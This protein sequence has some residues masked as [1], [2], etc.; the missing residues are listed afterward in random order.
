[1]EQPVEVAV[2]ERGELRSIRTMSPER[3]RRAAFLG[4]L[5]GGGLVL[6]AMAAA[7]GL[8]SALGMVEHAPTFLGAWLGV[9]G[10]VG[11]VSAR[12]A[13]GRVGRFRVGAGID[14]DAFAMTEL[15]LVRRVDG[16]YELAL[17]PGMSGSVESGRSSLPL[18]A[19][20]GRGASR[21]PMPP[22]G[23]VRIELGTSTFVIARGT[24]VPRAGAPFRDRARGL[25]AGVVRQLL[26][27]AALGTPLAALATFFGSVPAALAVT[28][29]DPRFAIPD[30][31]TPLQVEQL[32]RQKAQ[33]QSASLHEC[34]D[35]LPLACQKAGYV[36]IG[37]A[38][39]REGEVLSHWISRSTYGQ[40]CPVAACMDRI[41]SS[42]A[43]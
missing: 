37:L 43:F 39:S 16:G 34:F 1:V 8:V 7:A 18:E 25:G 12:R 4:A 6:A 26:R 19:L 41:V 31:A 42:W 14:A 13:A 2:F 27:A 22:E 20:S 11:L 40:D 21:V 9:A 38:L 3:E 32:I 10:A 23:R 35:P 17:V 15:D 5:W 30:T 33:L 36:G 28:D 29:S 24:E